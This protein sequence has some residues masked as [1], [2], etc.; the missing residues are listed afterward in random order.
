[1]VPCQ[2]FETCPGCRPAPWA[3][4]RLRQRP[5]QQ[6]QVLRRSPRRW[7]TKSWSRVRLLPWLQRLL[8]AWHGLQKSWTL[9]LCPLAWFYMYNSSIWWRNNQFMYIS[10]KYMFPFGSTIPGLILW[11]MASKVS[12]MHEPNHSMMPRVLWNSYMHHA[13]VRKASRRIRHFRGKLTVLSGHVMQLWP[14]SMELFDRS[15]RQ[16][17]LSDAIVWFAEHKNGLFFLCIKPAC[18]KMFEEPYI[19]YI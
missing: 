11:G 7:T 1:M 13:W 5:L 15:N 2:H 10:Q 19:L 4:D 8:I 12:W 14:L 18:T 6:H 9:L 17:N 3:L 16:R